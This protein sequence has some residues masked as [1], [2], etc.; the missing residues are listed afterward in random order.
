MPLTT[1]QMEMDDWDCREV[2]YNKDKPAPAQGM[3][4]ALTTAPGPKVVCAR[5]SPG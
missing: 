5:P 4:P 1:A 2:I 3:E